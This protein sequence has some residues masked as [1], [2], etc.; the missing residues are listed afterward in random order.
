MSVKIFNEDFFKKLN[1]INMHINFKLSSGT[2]GGRKS[3]AKGVS[4][5]FSDYREYAAGDDFRRIDWN[6]YGRFDKFFIKVFMEEREGVFNFFIDKSK[7]MDYGEV[8]KKDTALKVVGAL[9]YIALNNLDRVNINTMESGTVK[10][11]KSATGNKGFQ[12][13]LK[14]L[15]SMEFDGST[16]LSQSIKKRNLNSRGISIV[17]SD[18]LNNNGL[19][20]LEEGLKYLAFKKQ[21][22]ILVQILAEEEI[23]PQFNN[24]ITFIDSETN[25]NLKMSLTPSIIK[26]YKNSLKKYNKE[27]E[28]LVKK[29]GGKLISVSSSKSI[30][31][32]IL[33]DFSKKRV[34]Y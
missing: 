24:E 32:I 5:E 12:R 16:D 18:F 27:I 21:E 28:S 29:Y 31:E 13:I 8:N 6:A 34:L 7:S 15:E 14:E 19:E 25:E 10:S 9:S 2:Q 30:E 22:I 26:D 17:V 4:V 23:N 33:N 20:T 3:K 11:L 1:K